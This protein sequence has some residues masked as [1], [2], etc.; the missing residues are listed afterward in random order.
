MIDDEKK[1]L[2]YQTRKA[3]VKARMPL[4]ILILVIFVIYQTWL[5]ISFLKWLSVA[6]LIIYLGIGFYFQKKLKTEFK[7]LDDNKQDN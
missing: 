5:Q 7:K 4:V 1:K 3:K 2:I 6:V